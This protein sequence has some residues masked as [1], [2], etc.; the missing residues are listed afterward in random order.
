MG[1]IGKILYI[2]ELN[3]TNGC[4][5]CKQRLENKN[6]KEFFG[7]KENLEKIINSQLEID[8]VIDVFIDDSNSRYKRIKTSMKIRKGLEKIRK[9]SVK[10]RESILKHKKSKLV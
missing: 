2:L 8:K 1:I 4:P 3:I 6:K 7:I 5:K 9:A 10:L